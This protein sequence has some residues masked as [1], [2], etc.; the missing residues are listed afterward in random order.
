MQQLA[1][2]P[3]PAAAVL[4]LDGRGEV[5]SRRGGAQMRAYGRFFDRKGRHMR[6]D[7]VAR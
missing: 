2:F 1:V 5:A 3:D 7:E 4:V 6:I